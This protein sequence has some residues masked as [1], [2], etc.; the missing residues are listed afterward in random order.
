VLSTVR[1]LALIML[2][3]A[4]GAGAILEIGALADHDDSSSRVRIPVQVNVATTVAGRWATQNKKAGEKVETYFNSS[5]TPMP[6]SRATSLLTAL[7][8]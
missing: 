8:R 5:A 6:A 2:G 7:P 3:A 4:I 1:S